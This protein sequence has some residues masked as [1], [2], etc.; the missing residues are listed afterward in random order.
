[1]DTKLISIKDK[2]E[3]HKRLLERKTCSVKELQEVLGISYTKANQLVHI[4]GFPSLKL[5][6]SYRV[7]IDKL[8]AWLEENIGL[9]M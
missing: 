8:D 6:R 5:G 4:E 1:M 2:V 3:E 9:V 7:I